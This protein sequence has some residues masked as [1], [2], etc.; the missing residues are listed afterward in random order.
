MNDD[1][2]LQ[3]RPENLAS[4]MHLMF[5]GCVLRRQLLGI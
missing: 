3:F 1:I 4:C 5:Y 2:P